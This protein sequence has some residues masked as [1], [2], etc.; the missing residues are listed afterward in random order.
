MWLHLMSEQLIHLN[1]YS[2]LEPTTKL[3]QA[4][5]LAHVLH[6]HKYLHLCLLPGLLQK[7]VIWLDAAGFIYH[8]AVI[9]EGQV[10]TWREIGNL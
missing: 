8:A 6:K 4:V 1:H 9:L 10:E 3:K 5:D 2:Q 7:P